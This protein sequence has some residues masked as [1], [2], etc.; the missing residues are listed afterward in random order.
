MTD[1]PDVPL[2]KSSDGPVSLL[3]NRRIST[4]LSGRL[5]RGGVSPNA[6]TFVALLLGV[7]ASAA[8]AAQVWWAG[9]LL[10][11]LASVFAGVDGE[12]ARRTGKAT[13]YGDFFD[14]ITDRLVEYAGFVAIAVGLAQT[15]RW[16]GWAWP[17]GIAAVGGTFM[18]ALASE[19]YRS[20]MH[21]NYPKR[22]LEPFFA[23]LASGRDVRIFYLMVASFGAI[24]SL[25]I[26]VWTLVALAVVLHLN[27]FFRVLILR[28]R[29]DA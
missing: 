3:I 25:D 26:L 12:I 10:M 19:K 7:A 16:D 29:M 1:A 20:V 22:Q 5:A 18:L 4:R 24:W 27:F 23:Y 14:T 28:R 11:Q 15:D 17:L 8:Y 2:V 21:E 6:A 13:R 9:G